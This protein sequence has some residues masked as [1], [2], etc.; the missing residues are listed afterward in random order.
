MHSIK[1]ATHPFYS[2]VMY[3]QTFNLLLNTL[4]PVR[5]TSTIGLKHGFPH[6]NF[7]RKQQTCL[8]RDSLRPFYLI[9]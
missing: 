9:S 2:E 5:P 3:I 1:F 6:S 7:R 4:K 8:G